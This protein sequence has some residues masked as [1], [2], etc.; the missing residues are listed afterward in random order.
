MLRTC[1]SKEKGEPT[2]PRQPKEAAAR[3]S[4]AN[5]QARDKLAKGPK[6]LS[7]YGAAARAAP[8]SIKGLHSQEA[9]YGWRRY[10]YV[11]AWGLVDG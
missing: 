6:L 8:L 5:Q 9:L 1:C 4:A 2:S 11:G 7:Q 3:W 10:S